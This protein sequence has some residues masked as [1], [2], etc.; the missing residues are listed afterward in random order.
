MK[1]TAQ[2]T[3]NT[4]ASSVSDIL[5]LKTSAT[6]ATTNASV[7]SNDN[8]Q[9]KEK[10]S[11]TEQK[12]KHLTK[13]FNDTVQL[14]EK[15]SKTEQKIKHLTKA[16]ELAGTE[17]RRLRKDIKK[18]KQKEKDLTMELQQAE[19][20]VS[21]MEKGTSGSKC[22]IDVTPSKQMSTTPI[23][24]IVSQERLRVLE[25][26]NKY[27]QEIHSL[28]TK[29]E[30][31]TKQATKNKITTKQMQQKLND[32]EMKMNE[33]KEQAAKNKITAND[34]VSLKQ[35]RNT[36]I[37]QLQQQLNDSEMET[38]DLREQLLLTSK[39]SEALTIQINEKT[40]QLERQEMQRN[41]ELERVK[42]EEAM[43]T[44]RMEA[45]ESQIRALEIEIESTRRMAK[46]MESAAVMAQSEFMV[47][48]KMYIFKKSIYHC[49][50]ILY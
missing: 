1:I 44:M 20:I 27:I 33:L 39:K 17:V 38:N 15:L 50:T 5:T 30:Q 10:L 45:K 18:R 3:K 26:S 4:L 9:L 43:S 22:D 40:K 48:R 41:T 21:R 8:L 12:I 47:R 16:G 29:I 24:P 6:S 11:K 14:Q 34:Y 13:A 36:I 7:L 35:N 19:V 28:Q 46:S 49:I 31:M 37:T 42:N 2:E 23:T 32:S 25:A